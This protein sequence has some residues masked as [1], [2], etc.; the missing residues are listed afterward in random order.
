MLCA[1]F[2]VLARALVGRDFHG[3][4]VAS[5]LVPVA[6][7]AGFTASAGSVLAFPAG[8]GL[9]L[10]WLAAVTARLATAPAPR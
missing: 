1:A 2:V 9:G 10:L 6:V 3:W 5:R 7:L 4:A 8:A